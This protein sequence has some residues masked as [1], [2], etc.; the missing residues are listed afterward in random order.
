MNPAALPSSIVSSPRRARLRVAVVAGAA[1]SAC[2]L[3]GCWPRFAD[4]VLL[5]AT[6]GVTSAVL[7]AVVLV[8]ALCA[9]SRAGAAARALGMSVVLGF[10]ST[11]PPSMIL[12]WEDSQ[13]FGAYLVFGFFFGSFTGLVYGV[14]LAILAERTWDDVQAWTHDGTDRA[15]RT[16]AFWAIFP[17]LVAFGA[18]LGFDVTPL[19]M[20]GACGA[21]AA[22]VI[23]GLAFAWSQAR[24]A[25]RRAWVARIASGDDPRWSLRE[26]GP[27]D[28]V[29]ALARLGAGHFVVEHRE[30]EAAY[31]VA[32]NGRAVAVVT[33]E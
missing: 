26:L 21:F 24:I 20:L 6:L 22:F 10:V 16:A 33:L 8:I 32:A 29:G 7:G 3:A 11:I 1:V 27:H 25:Q 5:R 31:R 13:G 19:A 18:S 28:D 23:A 2:A 14:P 15:T 4:N 9:R 12:A 17:I 30:A